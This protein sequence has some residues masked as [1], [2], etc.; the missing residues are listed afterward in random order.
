MYWIYLLL[1][2]GCEVLG[3]TLMKISNGFTK[4]IPSILVVV[5][6]ILTLPFFTLAL[7]KINVSVAYAVWSGIGTA[8]IAIIGYILFKEQMNPVKIAAI[9]MIIAGIVMLNLSDVTRG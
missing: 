7:K 9:V 4:L 3:T 8:S 6:Y 1:A 2:I 5:F